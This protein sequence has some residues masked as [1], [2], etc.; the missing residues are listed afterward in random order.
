MPTA[1]AP[2]Q[3]L[4][5]RVTGHDV[6]ATPTLRSSIWPAPGSQVFIGVPARIDR[7]ALGLAVRMGH[8]DQRHVDHLDQP[9]LL[10]HT[11]H[12]R[13]TGALPACPVNQTG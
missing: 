11:S 3:G 9:S 7:A 10:M 4:P 2:C 13:P 12:Q 1:G 8:I 6:N 5:G